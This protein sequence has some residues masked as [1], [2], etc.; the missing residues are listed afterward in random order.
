MPAGGIV[1]YFRGGT[2]EVTDTTFLTQ[3]DSGAIGAPVVYMAYPGETPLFTGGKYLAGTG[4]E[5]V[6]DPDMLARLAAGARDNVV[7]IDLFANGF[8][9]RDLDYSQSFWQAGQIREF[10]EEDT[11]DNAYLT[12][13]LQVFIDD[14]ALDLARYPNKVPGIFAENPYYSYLR[15]PESLESGFDPDTERLTGKNAVFSTREN[16]IKKWSSYDDVI[17]AGMVGWEF[18]ADRILAR[19][20]DPEA[21][22]VELMGSAM[23]GVTKGSRYAFENVFEELDTPGEYFISREGYLYLY[24]A[25]KIDASQVKISKFDKNFMVEVKDAAHVMFSGLTFELTKGSVLYLHGGSDL[26]VQDCVFKN[27]GLNGIRVGEDVCSTR[28]LAAEYRPGQ[29]F[30][31][32]ILTEAARNG[33]NY[34]ITGSTF[35]NTGFN[36]AKIAT[37]SALTRESGN[38][39]FENNIIRHSGL[40]GSTYNSGLGL[41]GSGI[42]VKNNLFAFCLGQAIQGNVVDTKIIY[43]EFVDSPCD[44]AEDTGTIYLNYA[45]LNAGVEVRY[46]YFHDVTGIDHPGIGFDFARRGGGAYYDTEMPFKDFSYNV[47]YN[48]PSAP[49]PVSATGPWTN[50]NNIYVDVASVFDYPPEE[51][52]D[53]ADAAPWSSPQGMLTNIGVINL[54]YKN[55]F[56]REQYPE[57]IDYF[58]HLEK[59]SDLGELM[60]QVY[61]NVVVNINAP[62]SGRSRWTTGDWLDSGEEY[63]ILNEAPVDKKYGQIA[64]NLFFDVDPGFADYARQDFQFSQATAAQLGVQWI[65]MSKIGVAGAASPLRLADAYAAAETLNGV[66]FSAHFATAFPTSDPEWHTE[67]DYSSYLKQ[68]SLWRE[69]A[70]GQWEWVNEGAL[71]SEDATGIFVRPGANYAVYYHGDSRHFPQFVG[72]VRNLDE[73]S[74]NVVL[75]GEQKNIA[76]EAFT[77]PP[78]EVTK[79]RVKASCWIDFELSEYE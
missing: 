20:I 9:F 41:D 17:I 12:R 78:G 34:K 72:V 51:L 38:L 14:E 18:F 65:D 57:L 1:A 5:P 19:K 71:D 25:R 70:A 79:F 61:D 58:A 47:L 75:I 76:A 7:A 52:R 15:V 31:V 27:M 16:R 30:A 53:Y 46:N 45:G 59:K 69:V 42:T 11:H 8:T 36:A 64:N 49:Q 62:R 22:T 67:G 33:F 10:E 40:L 66:K 23:S 48:V 54:F 73:N 6:A 60:V 43:N 26:T 56:W 63:P 3:E 21:M 24:P 77:P 55:Q 74:G 32:E 68:V 29:P 44:L 2:Y 39:L 28:D 4:F 50:I 37:G 13:R 35:L